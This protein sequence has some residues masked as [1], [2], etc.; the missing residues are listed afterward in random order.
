[1]LCALD[2][3]DENIRSPMTEPVIQMPVPAAT[4]SRAGAL[5]RTVFRMTTLT[6]QK[7]LRPVRQIN[8]PG[9]SAGM[10]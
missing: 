3:V 10:N 6:L 9:C 7:T 8:P 4:A 1:M 2:S 5:V